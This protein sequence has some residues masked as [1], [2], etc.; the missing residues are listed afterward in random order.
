M[1]KTERIITAVLCLSVLFASFQCSRKRKI[2][3]LLYEAGYISVWT[4][5][6]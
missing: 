2:Q 4:S 5:W 3:I 6:F 1:A